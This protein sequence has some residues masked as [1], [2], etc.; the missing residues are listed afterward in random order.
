MVLRWK[1]KMGVALCLALLIH[2]Y[3]SQRID[4]IITD[5]EQSFS[6]METAGK[7]LA[8]LAEKGEAAYAAS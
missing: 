2:A 8:D 1:N 5:M 7:K 3:F 4:N 6:L